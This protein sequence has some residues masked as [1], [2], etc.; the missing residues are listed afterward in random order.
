[1]IKIIFMLFLLSTFLFSQPNID[2][3]K[4][5]IKRAVGSQKVIK[6]KLKGQLDLRR[7]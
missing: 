3:L 4:V 1:M 5:E 7:L 2:S 6:W